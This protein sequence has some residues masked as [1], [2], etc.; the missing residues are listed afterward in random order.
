[1]FKRPLTLKSAK[2]G[3]NQHV[4]P[5]DILSGQFRKLENYH[6]DSGALL[7]KRR[8][9]EL[10]Q[11]GPIQPVQFVADADTTALW[12]LTEA[13][14]HAGSYADT[15]GNSLDLAPNNTQV[16][17]G[18]PALFTTGVRSVAPNPL[19]DGGV[20]YRTVTS[21]PLSANFQYV[22]FELWVNIA[23]QFG[24]PI[25]I[26]NVSP[27]GPPTVVSMSGA[28]LLVLMDTQNLATATIINGLQLCQDYK[29]PG[30]PMSGRVGGPYA[31]FTI[32]TALD[33]QVI[34]T[35]DLP[36]NRWFLIRGTYNGDSGEMQVYSGGISQDTVFLNGAGAMVGLGAA[37]GATAA[38]AGEVDATGFNKSIDSSIVCEARISSVV[39]DTW[40][41]GSPRSKAFEYSKSDGTR[42][43]ILAA[44]D[45]LYYTVGDGAWNVL[46][47]GFDTEAY[48]DMGQDGDFFYMS[49]GNDDPK[50]WDGQ[51]LV[52]WGNP[53]QPPTLTE[54]ASGTTLIA[55]TREWAY[56]YVYGDYETGLSPSISF[57]NSN[58]FNV[59]VTDIPSRLTNCT[60][61][62]VYRTK[63][64][65]S[66]F[67][68]IR[69]IENP[70]PGTNSVSMTGPYVSGGSPGTDSGADG[71]ADASVGGGSDYTAVSGLVSGT[72]ARKPKYLI[73]DQNRVFAFGMEDEPYTVRWGEL[74]APDVFRATS[75]TK[76]NS[77][78]GILIGGAKHAGEKHFSKSG[79]ATLVLRGDSPANWVQ[80]EWLHP[81]VGAVD[82]WSYV[83]R[84]IPGS[85]SSVLCFLAKDGFYEYDGYRFKKISEDIPDIV[86]AIV[87]SN[88]SKLD[89]N[90]TTT[91]QFLST[92]TGTN[93]GSSTKNIIADTYEQDGMRQTAGR[94][95]IVDQKDYIGLWGPGNPLV[96]GSI[97]AVCKG[98]SEGVFY[99]CTTQS[100]YVHY[101]ADNFVNATQCPVPLPNDQRG[102]ELLRYTD[103]TT[104]VENLVIFTA[105]TGQDY[106]S[107]Y[108]YED[109]L[110]AAGIGPNMI[111]LSTAPTGSALGWRYQLDVPWA[112]LASLYG[113]FNVPPAGANSHKNFYRIGNGGGAANF[114]DF[115]GGNNIYINHVQQVNVQIS[116]GGN[117]PNGPSVNVEAQSSLTSA[118]LNYGGELLTPGNPPFENIK[119]RYFNLD[120]I[121]LP[122]GFYG[123][124]DDASYTENGTQSIWIPNDT[125]GG[126]TTTFT[127]RETA[128]WSGGTMRPQSIYFNGDSQWVY[129]V[130]AGDENTYGNINSQLWVLNL[131]D[132]SISAIDNNV[133]AIC[134]RQNTGTLYYSSLYTPAAG[135]TGFIGQVSA[136][137]T[138]F[139]TADNFA[140]D[141]YL[142]TR[143]CWNQS[144]NL[145]SGQGKKF[146]SSGDAWE[147]TGFVAAIAQDATADFV[148]T[149][150]SGYTF[151]A[152][153]DSGPVPVEVAYQTGYPNAEHIA[154][155]HLTD[156]ALLAL[157]DDHTVLRVERSD[158]YLSPTGGNPATGICSNLLFV[159]QSGNTGDYLWA[160]RLYFGTDA[161]SSSD[162]RFVQFGV[163]GDWEVHGEFISDQHNLGTFNAF[164]SFES[165]FG[166]GGLANLVLFFFRNALDPNDLVTSDTSIEANKK[167]M[168]KLFAPVQP[169]AQWRFQLIWINSTTAET[170]TPYVNFIDVGYYLGNPSNPRVVAEHWNDRTYWS[171]AVNGSVENNLVCVYQRDN[172]WTTY[173]GL[174]L[175]SLCK[176]R[177]DLV[178]LIGNDL[179]RLDTGYTD[180]GSPI[181]GL[182]WTGYVLGSN[183]LKTIR[184]I[185]ATVMSQ[186]S[187]ESGL[188]TGWIKVVP[189]QAETA[190]IAAEWVFPLPGTAA[191]EGRMVAGQPIDD[192]EFGW[193]T[194]FSLQISTSDGTTGTFAPVVDQSEVIKEIEMLILQTGS[195]VPL[196]VT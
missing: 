116:T 145:L 117:A 172:T 80:F 111:L 1:M 87:Q 45:K 171:L 194:S 8:G 120:Y 74:A 82:H 110:G 153:G 105:L 124:H 180:L 96:Q 166:T 101:T 54:T 81:T 24:R 119:V 7:E 131:A 46:G 104:S 181:L 98:G 160:D 185:H 169:F 84:V 103:S 38:I 122:V 97:T 14:P 15:S 79:N 161:A 28:P 193:A 177:G 48:W 187:L 133:S 141:N 99:F 53:T 6:T 78:Q 140:Q 3:L 151:V 65:D 123:I 155:D 9:T 85:D 107:I 156:A 196:V 5:L 36:R 25:F 94:V 61:I 115:T 125:T 55:G 148:L 66:Q 35:A 170:T 158:G 56:S 134:L 186:V 62:R 178:G 67:Y 21:S 132:G 17:S 112:A 13:G 89:W 23:P 114:F 57:T 159:P 139:I 52:D 130:A 109:P 108:R 33:T 47:D 64:G 73:F 63:S 157:T 188:P 83:E 149:E 58:G 26:P 18:I 72:L 164:G 192:F 168:A 144:T 59:N 183:T 128:L 31:T 40:P 76:A 152:D 143:L 30:N 39:R 91:P 49:N 4:K 41:F 190:L 106:G 16:F 126:F 165:D 95:A 70:N 11:Y 154:V 147:Y 173:T 184:S 93:A 10:I 163:D 195:R 42:Q 92:Q 60:S 129:F 69:E 19:T 12:T 150:P 50:C 32:Q 75:F 90:V 175:S 182:A 77:D 167:I 118:I 22:T 136:Q 135:F 27:P 137:T 20:V 138:S 121:P 162:A 71:V 29:T 37:S 88:S 51:R 2:G 127:R 43:L 68:L 179:V 44:E 142:P 189:I 34:R 102:I 176:F 174:R 86:D 146:A 191:L 113:N 100:N